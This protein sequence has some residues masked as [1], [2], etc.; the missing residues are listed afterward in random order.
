[1]LKLLKTI[2]IDSNRTNVELL[3]ILFAKEPYNGLIAK[4]ETAFSF[5]EAVLKFTGRKFELSIIGLNLGE[6]KDFYELFSIFDV[7]TFGIVVLSALLES[8]VALEKIQKI[9]DYILLRQPFNPVG[10]AE[11][12]IDLERKIQ[13]RNK[14]QR[15]NHYLIYNDKLWIAIPYSE[16]FYIETKGGYSTIFCDNTGAKEKKFLI[17]KNLKKIAC[18]VDSGILKYCHENYI[19]NV[20]KIRICELRGEGGVIYFNLFKDKNDQ[21][22]DVKFSKNFKQWLIE[23]GYL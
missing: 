14:N 6:N 8:E 7:D 22:F 23:N 17:R 5:D 9:R 20:T 4:P 18:E 16:I 13:Q 2:I 15:P 11:F 10:I 1:M 19:V 3:E 12:V 21:K